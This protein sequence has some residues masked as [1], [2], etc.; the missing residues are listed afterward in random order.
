MSKTLSAWTKLE[1]DNIEKQ[2]PVQEVI[3]PPEKK[4][5][6]LN[7][8]RK[9]LQKWNTINKISKLLNDSTVSKFVKKMGRGKWF[10]KWPIFCQQKYKV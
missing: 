1:D 6:I 9:V 7:K 5:K 8:L 4:E 2:E 10:I 3:I